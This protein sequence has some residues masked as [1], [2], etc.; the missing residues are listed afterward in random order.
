MDEECI[1]NP[2]IHKD[3]KIRQDR[4]PMKKKQL[5]TSQISIESIVYHE[6]N[7]YDAASQGNLPVCVLLWGMATSKHVHIMVPD[8]DG[9]NPFHLA[10]NSNS[11]EVLSFLYQQTKGNL[12]SGVRLIASLNNQSETPLM[13][14]ATKGHLPIIKALLDWK[15]DIY[16]VDSNKMTVAMKAAKFKQIWVL[17]FILNFIKLND[18]ENHM[19]ALLQQRDNDGR[20]VLDWAAYVGDVNCI[21]LLIRRG[22]SPVAV[23]IFNRGALYWSV[24]NGHVA[25]TRFL[26]QI[27]CDV[28]QKDV[29]GQNPLHLAYSNYHSTKSDND[30]QLLNVVL[31]STATAASTTN[32]INIHCSMLSYIYYCSLFNNQKV[33]IKCDVN[34]SSCSNNNATTTT[35]AI[36]MIDVETGLPSTSTSTSCLRMETSQIPSSSTSSDVEASDDLGSLHKPSWISCMYT[37]SI[38][39][40]TSSNST[41]VSSKKLSNISY[42]NMIK[43]KIIIKNKQNDNNNNDENNHLQQQ[44]YISHNDT[45][46]TNNNN[47]HIHTQGTP[48]SKVIYNINES[49]MDVSMTIAVAVFIIWLLTLAMPWWLWILLTG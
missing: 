33:N 27:G 47:H 22:I 30:R 29:H 12:H 37:T 11:T 28:H 13:Y 23:S 6:I 34:S 10:C 36:H 35:N 42:F 21:E 40:D 44:E 41:R 3:N 17:N 26:I 45:S 15:S 8:K 9:N 16:T 49:R 20:N 2:S 24:K 31:Y 14:A 19:N 39:S 1:Y 18:G 25:A 4:K 38:T 32:S 48:R 46:T 7:I 5:F 43:S